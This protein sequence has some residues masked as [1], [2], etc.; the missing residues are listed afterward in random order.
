M[1]DFKEIFFTKAEAEQLTAATFP[2]LKAAELTADMRYL[3]L[4][5]TRVHDELKET[6]LELR[7]LIKR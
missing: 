6:R 3:K 2:Q 5:L 7:E 4:E 1:E